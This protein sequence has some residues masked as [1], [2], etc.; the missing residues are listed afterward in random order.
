MMGLINKSGLSVSN[1]LKS[2]HEELLRGTGTVIG[3]GA[4]IFCQNESITAKYIIV[5]KDNGLNPPTE[6]KFIVDR[7]KEALELFQQWV[8]A[9]M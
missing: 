8:D 2:I 9:D 7:Y 3:A 6:R 1:N 4:S 5:S